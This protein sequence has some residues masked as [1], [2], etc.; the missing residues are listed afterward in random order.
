LISLAVMA[1]TLFQASDGI[2]MR[3][4]KFSRPGVEAPFIQ[5]HEN[6]EPLD[7][8]RLSPQKFGNPAHP[9]EFP[10]VY[11]AFVPA[12]GLAADNF[13]LRFRVYAQEKKEKDDVG[14]KTARMLVN[15]WSEMY[16]RANIDHSLQY[17]R[18]IVDVFLCYGGQA[19]GE[20]RFEITTENGFRKNVNDIYV[21]DVNSFTDPMEMAREIAHEYGHAVLPAIGGYTAPEVWANGFLGEKVFLSWVRDGMSEGRLTPDDAMGAKKEQIDSWLAA[22]SDP[23]VL[24]A[25]KVFPTPFSLKDPTAKG[26]DKYLGL[27]LLANE[28]L[29]SKVFWHS[30]L[31]TGSTNA[32]DYPA[33]LLLA[34]AEP[35]EYEINIPKLL[36]DKPVWLPTGKGKIT[37][38]KILKLMS[39][40]A[41]VQAPEGKLKV[42]NPHQD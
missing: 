37:G 24:A 12:P 29:P 17:N 33:A 8:A 35:E 4:A 38:G 19:G 2:P 20:Q 1:V 10:W 30:L 40:W 31:F 21:Y 36:A 39:G 25:S 42:T 7:P 16:N 15:L 28:V 18:Q 11:R 23:L 34:T 13:A 32:K 9:W 14:A 26:M 5:I 22:H 3:V 41:Q 27:A 6:V